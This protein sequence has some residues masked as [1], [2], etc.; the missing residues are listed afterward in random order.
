MLTIS[1]SVVPLGETRICHASAP[2]MV[3]TLTEAGPF[4]G[5][6]QIVVSALSTLAKNTPLPSGENVIGL[7]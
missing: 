4:S 5:C 3:I 6:L 2:G 1:P 7:K